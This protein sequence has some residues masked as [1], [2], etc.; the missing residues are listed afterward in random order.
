M[1]LY[2]LH[3]TYIAMFLPNAVD[4]F[5]SIFRL[6]VS[7]VELF[8]REQGNRLRLKIQFPSL[9]YPCFVHG[10]EMNGPLNFVN[11]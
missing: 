1:V 11:I 10:T 2:N 8:A 4:V 3:F 9:E 5:L 7:A 6:T